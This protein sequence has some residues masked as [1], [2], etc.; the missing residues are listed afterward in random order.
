MSDK[1]KEELN[2]AAEEELVRALAKRIHP[3][4]CACGCHPRGKWL[5][6][7]DVPADLMCFC[8]YEVDRLQD[9]IRHELRLWEETR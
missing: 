2:L 4:M 5:D 7:K 3:M 6:P 1:T 8:K 9:T